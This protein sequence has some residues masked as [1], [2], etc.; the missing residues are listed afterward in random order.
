MHHCG[1][2]EME[3]SAVFEVLL[4]QLIVLQISLD[5]E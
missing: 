2:T 3:K 5:S 4:A 1:E